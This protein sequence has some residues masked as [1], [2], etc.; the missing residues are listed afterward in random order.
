MSLTEQIIQEID[1]LPPT[2]LE[3]IYQEVARRMS[4]ISRATKLLAKYRG[5]GRGIWSMDAQD[6]VKQLRQDTRG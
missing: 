1:L 3:V 2:E 6:Y 4:N 5:K